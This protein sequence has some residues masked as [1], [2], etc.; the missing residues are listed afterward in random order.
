MTMIKSN[1]FWFFVS[2]FV[3]LQSSL[4]VPTNTYL[5]MCGVY[6]FLYPYV[7]LCNVKTRNNVQINYKH[8]K[9]DGSQA[10]YEELRDTQRSELC[11]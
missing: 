8:S 11:T 1:S 6:A 7:L 5:V 3:P 2:V 10:T 4:H 9:V